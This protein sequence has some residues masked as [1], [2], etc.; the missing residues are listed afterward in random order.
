VQEEAWGLRGVEERPGVQ[1]EA[2]GLRGGSGRA[3]G[4]GVQG[5]ASEKALVIQGEA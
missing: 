1:E 2:W 3:L 4:G 5:K